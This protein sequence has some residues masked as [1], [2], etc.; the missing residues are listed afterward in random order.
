MGTNSH[1]EKTIIQKGRCTPVFFAALFT[2]ART[3]KQTKCP[4]TGACIKKLWYR[5]TM[6]YYS[7]TK[8]N[9]FESVLVRWMNLKPVI[10]SAVSPKE[11]S[12]YSVLTH[13]YRI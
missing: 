5:Y 10:Q 1:P 9:K 6:E 2:I 4:L 3:R 11:K 13:I 12:K 8:K 7:T